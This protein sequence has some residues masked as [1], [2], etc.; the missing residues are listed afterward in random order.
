MH[1]QPLSQTVKVI[2]EART[3]IVGIQETRSPKRDDAEKLAQ[4]LGWNYDVNEKR[5]CIVT[6]YKIVDR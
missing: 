6:R 5:S 2:H 3:D 1:R 4:L